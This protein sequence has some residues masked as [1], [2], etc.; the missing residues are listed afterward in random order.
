[1]KNVLFFDNMLTPKIITFVYWLLLL[2]AAIGGLGAMFGGYEGFTIGK[3][4]MGLLYTAGGAVAIRMWCELLI[5]LFKM[6][7]ALQELR[8]K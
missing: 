6:N 8:H 5:V 2:A 1:M 3:F 4:F 7:E